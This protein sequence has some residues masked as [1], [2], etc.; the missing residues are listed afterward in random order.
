MMSAAD[1]LQ[2]ELGAELPPAIGALGDVE[3][4]VLTGALR[5]ARE[6]QKQALSAATDTGLRFVPRLLRGPVK[7]VLFG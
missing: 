5:R 4:A 7:K 6:H 1:E 2:D 3:L